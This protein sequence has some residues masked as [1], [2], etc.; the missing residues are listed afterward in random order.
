MKTPVRILIALLIS[1]L[2]TNSY[3]PSALGAAKSKWYSE[4]YAAI[5]ERDSNTLA[6]WGITRA[7]GATGKPVKSK[8]QYFCSTFT[9]W[10]LRPEDVTT[11]LSKKQKLAARKDWDAGC[12]SAGMLLKL[13]DIKGSK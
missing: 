13:S 7:F 5:M 10:E 11:G 8:M 12:L 1:T 6:K 3:A 2:V 9:V 4:G